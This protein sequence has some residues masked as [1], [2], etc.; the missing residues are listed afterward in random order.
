MDWRQNEI[1]VAEARYEYIGIC[2]DC[3]KRLYWCRTE[4]RADDALEGRV[5]KFYGDG[6]M[7]C[8]ECA[9]VRDA[10]RL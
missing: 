1:V 5:A 10:P 2:T 9:E 4:K 7:N 6:T 3:G 8:R